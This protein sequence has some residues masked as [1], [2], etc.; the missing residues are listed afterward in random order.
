M[1]YIKD[2]IFYKKY[3]NNIYRREISKIPQE[4][5]KFTFAPPY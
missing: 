3:I 5:D 1:R 4:T 2:I